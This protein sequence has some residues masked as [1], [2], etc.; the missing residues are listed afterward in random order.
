MCTAITMKTAQGETFFGRTMDFSYPLDPHVF[1]TPRGY[2]WN[3]ITGKAAVNNRYGFIGTAQDIGRVIFADGVNEAGFSAAM[4]YFPGY[5]YFPE[6]GEMAG[7]EQAVQIAAVEIVNFLLGA[8]GSVAQAAEVLKQI[9]IVGV[10]DPVTETVAPLHWITAD[11]SGDCMVAEQT[12]SGLH[13]YRNPIGVL[14][15]SPDFEWHMANLRNYTGVSPD[16]TEDSKWG[17]VELSPFGQGS[18]TTGLPGGYTPPSRFVRTAFIKNHVRVPADRNEA[19]VTC[20][21]AME[22]VT[23]PK[24]IVRTREGRDDYTQY[25]AFVNTATGEYFAKSYDNSQIVTARLSEENLVGT[26]PVS[27]GKLTRPVAFA[28]V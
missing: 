5:A 20:F 7:G 24:G 26:E 8:C 28:G 23:L 27:L 6:P 18:G 13:L 17:D 3:S 16:Q 1:V 21:H 9:K 11:K 2:G 25:T 14:A 12:E 10:A 19:V 22:S 15:N 4:L